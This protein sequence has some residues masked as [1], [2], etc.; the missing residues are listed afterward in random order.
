[1][2]PDF[3]TTEYETPHALTASEI[4]GTVQAFREGAA[5]AKAAGFDGVEIHGANGYLI[6][7][8]L[9]S[10]TNE[11][12]DA[13]GGSVPNRVRLLQEVTA[14]VLEEWA[15]ERVGCRLSF[16]QGANGATDDAPEATFAFAAE[17]LADAGLAYL[18]AIRAG[19]PLNSE[20]GAD[21]DAIALARRH[22]RG[23]LIANAGYDR[24]SGERAV[25]EGKAD[26]VAYGRPFLA[27][28][29]LP[30]RFAAQEAG[31]DAPLN[32]PIPSTFYGGGPEGYTD[33]PIWDGTG[34][35]AE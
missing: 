2:L 12:T 8:F 9:S 21:V 31:L 30:I 34:T 5:N 27:N 24:A 7:Q 3:S 23:A 19:S 33:Y 18:H 35:D 32:E 6:E 4:A 29:D 22:F 15:P 1:M 13:Y 10:G 25:T 16:G 11:R 26:L 20:D 28:P 17:R 14:A